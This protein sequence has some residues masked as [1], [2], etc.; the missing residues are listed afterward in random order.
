MNN[1]TTFYI[2]RHGESEGNANHDLGVL[3]ESSPLGSNLTELGIRQ[4]KEIAKKFN[5]IKF[6][7]VFS[8]DFI[9]AHETAKIITEKKN[10]AIETTHILRERS[11]GKIVGD[12]EKK[13]AK[14]TGN[15]FDEMEHM[16]KEEQQTLKKEYDIELR[17]ETTSRIITF[18][19]EVAIAYPGKTILIT[20]HGAIMRSLLIHLG[21]GTAREL[22]SGSVR[23]ASYFVLQNDSVDF[24]LKQTDGI[25]KKEV[26]L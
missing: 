25:S 14:K 2:V 22:P 13:L 18:L 26:D 12:L 16:T 15:I 6:V 9:R 21:Y 4:V 19:R 24:F 20:C 11:R 3:L 17:E 8:S 1:L 7:K 5:S 10:L 23:N